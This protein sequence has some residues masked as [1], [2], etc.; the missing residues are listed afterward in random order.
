LAHPHIHI[1]AHPH[2]TRGHY[3]E[4]YG[5]YYGPQLVEINNFIMLYWLYA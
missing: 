5:E 2:F 1:S 4:Y 3:N